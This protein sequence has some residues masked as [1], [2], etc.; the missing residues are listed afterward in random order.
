MKLLFY[1]PVSL[2]NGG[3]GEQWQL[4]IAPQLRSL[5][6]DIEIIACA[7]GATN[8]PNTVIKQRLAGVQYT[9]LPTRSLVGSVLPTPAARSLL[10]KR[11]RGVDA[12]HYIFGF[13]GHDLLINKLAAQAGA[14]VFAG[15]HSPI[16]IH[17]T[18]HNL[19]VGS[20]SRY[21]AL[22]HCRGFFTF[23]SEQAATLK[24]WGLTQ[25]C[26]SIAG[27]IDTDHFVV[28]DTARST[29]KLELLYVGRFEYEKGIDILCEAIDRWLTKMPQPDIRLTILGSGSYES[30]VKELAAKYPQQVCFVPYTA[31][32]LPYYQRAQLL[33]VPSRQDTFG[34]VVVEALATGIPVLAAAADG[35][36]RILSDKKIGWLINAI[37]PDL[38]TKKMTELYS[39]WKQNPQDWQ[40]YEVT[41]RA[42]AM[43]YSPAVIAQRMHRTFVTL[44]K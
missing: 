2:R 17:N 19:Y 24:Q 8:L 5:G 18:V 30:V 37:T 29:K 15:F 10:H 32:T 4:A 41:T 42:A 14:K 1:S 20:V 35:P 6:H 23:N 38:L 40:R 33:V 43:Q 26:T 3:G 16:F 44:A 27:G 12:V 22:P 34:F 21:L 39:D 28:P 31:N 13:I 11:L 9:E 25:P 7:S 36:R